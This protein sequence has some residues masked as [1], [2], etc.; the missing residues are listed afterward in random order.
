M[1]TVHGKS[2]SLN[3]TVMSSHPS[4]SVAGAPAAA[5]GAA[6]AVASCQRKLTAR[7]VF[8][9]KTLPIY[10]Q[11][12]SVPIDNYMRELIARCEA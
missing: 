11:K 8:C 6:A 7:G 5:A 3:A 2:V 12:I 4:P 10:P 1:A 9:L